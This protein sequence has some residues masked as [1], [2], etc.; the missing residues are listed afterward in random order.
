M[1]LTTQEH[2]NR[3]VQELMILNLKTIEALMDNV[4]KMIKDSQKTSNGVKI[5][6]ANQLRFNIKKLRAET[7]TELKK[8]INHKG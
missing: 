3:K 5:V 7:T 6:E 1:M 2:L 4:D 8:Y